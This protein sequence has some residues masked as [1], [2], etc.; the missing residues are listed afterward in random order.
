MKRRYSL[1]YPAVAVILLL[2]WSCALMF[3]SLTTGGEEQLKPAG[4]ATATGGPRVIIF[5]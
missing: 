3:K 4:A 2:Q 5:A 1:M